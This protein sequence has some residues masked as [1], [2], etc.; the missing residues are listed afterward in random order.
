MAAA[1]LGGSFASPKPAGGI[2]HNL[3][4]SEAAHEG[5]PQ[6]VGSTGAVRLPYSLGVAQITPGSSRE[7]TPAAS[8]GTGLISTTSADSE[9]IEGERTR[10]HQPA[11]QCPPHLPA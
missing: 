8:E 10:A 7:A 11:R 3:S 9:P 1:A 5:T 6:P 4:G 2:P